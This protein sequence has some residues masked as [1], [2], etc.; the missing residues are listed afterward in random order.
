MDASRQVKPTYRLLREED[1][2]EV[3]RLYHRLK[4]VGRLDS[5]NSNDEK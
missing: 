2:A 1:E 5:T 4:K 3:E